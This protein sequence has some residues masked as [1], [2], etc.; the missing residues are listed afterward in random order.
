MASLKYRRLRARG[1]NS[2]LA[3]LWG[4]RYFAGIGNRATLQVGT[5]N[6]T[7]LF[8]A[9]TPGTGGNAI[10]IRYVVA[11][12]NTPLSVSVA[13]SAITVNVATNGASAPISK[14]SDVRNAINFDK[15][16]GPLVWVEPVEGSDATGTVAAF[17]P[18]NLSGAV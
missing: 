15:V 13:G 1:L 10:T 9:R 11:G 8:I 18:T 17:G 7:Q 3:K 5:G 6:A 4:N 14:A 12:A 2:R 16:A